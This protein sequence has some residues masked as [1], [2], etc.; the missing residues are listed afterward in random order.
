MTL[1]LAL[2]CSEGIVLASDGQATC[3]AAGQPTRQPVR[4]LFAAGDALAWGAA[5]SAGLQQS[6]HHELVDLDTRGATDWQLRARLSATVVPIQQAAL[7]AFVAHPG[8]E[9]P[10]LACLF[11]WWTG[12][13]PRILSVPRTG[14][15]HQFHERFAAIGSGDIFAAL[16]MRSI[17]HLETAQLSFEHA[18]MVAYTA[19]C[20]AIDVAAVYL[21]PPIQMYLVSPGRVEEVPHEELV[22][23][24]ADAVDVWKAR[25][26]EVLRPVGSP[27]EERGADEPLSAA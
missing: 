21:G 12:S 1:V 5:G 6:L 17:A 11:C 13:E 25:Q 15:D 7:R 18:K 2:R 23:Q 16:T 22:G 26:R 9:P 3:D 19:M 20:D 4:K 27:G 10:E 8:C 24:L 14:G